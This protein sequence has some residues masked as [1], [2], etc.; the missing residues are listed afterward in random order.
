MRLVVGTRSSPLAQR[1]TR[2]VTDLVRG[3][4]PDLEISVREFETSGDLDQEVPITELDPSAFTDRLERAL[5]EGEI[6]IAVHSCKDLPPV[7]PAELVIGAI[8][9]RADVRE[10]LVSRGGQ[11]LSELPPAAV[12]GVSS[13]RR[14]AVLLSIRPD[15]TLKPIRGA[16]DARVAKV[17]R[18]EYD[19]TILAVAGL[20]RLDLAGKIAEV[21][22]PSLFP[23]AAG[24]GALAVQCRRDNLSAR[25]ILHAIDDPVLHASVD[26]ERNSFASSQL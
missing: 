7:Q 12:V 11:R 25:S 22:D 9:V 10:A 6:D 14:A 24:Q 17:E 26:A 19:A 4:R 13:E 3:A 1:Q 5:I 16:V 20:E 18:G 23:P 2:I 15:L 21:F 8:P